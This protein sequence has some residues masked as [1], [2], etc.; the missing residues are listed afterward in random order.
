MKKNILLI[1]FDDAVA[2]WPYKT[3]FNE[4]L[5]I[6]NI[7]RL[8]A[9]ST[10]FHGAYAQA[11][12]CGPSRASMMTTMMP[13]ELGIL[14]NTIFAFDVIAPTSVWTH[15]L[16]T[17]GYYCSSGG[18]VHH[19]YIPL[20]PQDHE[21]LYD[22]E[23]KHF[24]DDMGL[25]RELRKRAT[26]FGGNRNGRGTRDGVD[27]DFYYDAQSAD[28]AI[29]FL[30]AYDG[31]RPFYREVG[32][33]SPHVPHLTPARFKTMYDA[34]NLRRPPEWTGY[35]DDN[36]FVNETL[37][38]QEELRSEEWW[39]HSV[40]NYF[41]AYSHGDHHLGRVLDALWQSRH[42][43]NTVVVL[44][45]DHGF[46]LGNRNLFRKMTMWEQSLRVP[47]IVFDPA[48]PVAQQID[49]PV[50]LIDL[51]P[52][53]LDYAGVP[54]IERRHGRS[55]RPLIEG[56]RDPGRAVPSFLRQNVSM[57][58][59]GLRIIRYGDG[60]HQMFDVG[61]DFWQLND[62]GPGD[63]RFDALRAEL[64]DCARDCGFVY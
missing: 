30:D 40:R 21:V 22:D 59:D 5:R 61:R 39:Q 18:K 44:I 14:D 3:V 28:S 49:D 62:L 10:A 16:R 56:D 26:K 53:V 13:H 34:T 9:V 57:I 38:E 29:G 45:S 19:R 46:H 15:Q 1:S 51:G 47:F 27:D 52:T 64:R 54:A 25:P 37:P 11:P 33:Y 2:P 58:K 7:D 43:E 63:P 48:R 6:P 35:I 36:A 23:R 60:S 31:D 17:H 32:F 55:L 50:G 12:L 41:S 20:H 24:S 8:C 4:P 42:A